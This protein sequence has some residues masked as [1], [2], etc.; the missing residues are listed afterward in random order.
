MRYLQF[1]RNDCGECRAQLRQFACP[2]GYRRALLERFRVRLHMNRY[3]PLDADELRE[4]RDELYD[5]PPLQYMDLS[6]R[7]DALVANFAAR[8]LWFTTGPKEAEFDYTSIDPNTGLYFDP[9]E[10]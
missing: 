4:V 9:S 3:D 10:S 5:A 6:R 2:C 8:R 1:T 7:L